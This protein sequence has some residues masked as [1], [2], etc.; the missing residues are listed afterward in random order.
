M[1]PLR[2]LGRSALLLAACA[3]WGAPAQAF[4]LT[5]ID[6]N[7]QHLEALRG[8]WV[9]LNVWATWCAPCI[10]EMPDL[11]ALA[12]ARRDVAVLGL[13]ADGDNPRKLRQ[14]AQALHVTYPIV[15]GSGEL[16]KTFG[17]NAYPTTF[18]Y[19]PAGSL[20]MT[21][22]GQVTRAELERRLGAPAG[23]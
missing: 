8:K 23:N 5:D 7:R 10:H 13:A 19:D 2:T 22:L 9:V 20:V 21:K 12:R 6:G 14:Y 1:K 11:E 15:A 16:L 17:V 3:L 18:V 4:H